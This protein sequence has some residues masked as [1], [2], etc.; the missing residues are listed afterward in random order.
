MGPAERVRESL[1]LEDTQTRSVRQQAGLVVVNAV[2][3]ATLDLFSVRITK[4][5]MYPLAVSVPFRPR[6]RPT[7]PGKF[8]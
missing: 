6:I 2:V 8:I 5:R 1:I 4:L 3:G 7:R